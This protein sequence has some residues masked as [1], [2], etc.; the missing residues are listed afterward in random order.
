[1]SF[2]LSRMGLTAAG[3]L[4][5]PEVGAAGH[6]ERG[7]RAERQNDPT[8][9][10]HGALPPRCRPAHQGSWRRLCSPPLKAY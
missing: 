1:M 10:L 4:T 2:P 7:Q 9:L 5:R 3:G 8:D 6:D